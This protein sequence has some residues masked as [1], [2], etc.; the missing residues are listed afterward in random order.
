MK[1]SPFGRFCVKFQ[2]KSNNSNG[3]ENE[4]Y[5]FQNGPAHKDLLWVCG[6]MRNF[7][8]GGNSGHHFWVKFLT[9]DMVILSK[10][11]ND[12][13]GNSTY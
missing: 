7:E 12:I 2:G 13:I 6:E 9:N 4:K 11:M 5:S 10:H 3:L 8:L 1:I